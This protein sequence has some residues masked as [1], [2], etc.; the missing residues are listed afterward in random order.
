[1][2]RAA[3]ATTAVVSWQD[4]LAKEAD[5]AAGM[6]AGAGGG[7]WF[8]TRGGIL[9]LGDVAIPDNQIAVVILDSVIENIYYDQDFNPD[10]LTPPRCFALGRDEATLAPHENVVELGQEEHETCTGCPRNEWGSARRGKGKACA[11]RRRLSLL[12]AGDLAGKV[13]EPYEMDHYETSPVALLKLPVTSVKLFANYVKQI[14]A[15]Y[16]RPPFGVF[17]LVRLVPDPKTM[18]RVDISMIDKVPD[19]LLPVIMRR[20]R[21][22]QAMLE[23][24]Q[25]LEYEEPAP[26][27]ARVARGG[28]KVAAKR[29][30]Y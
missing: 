17:S 8:S 13:F 21:E 20:R 29:A 14:S 15:V 24:P 1:M 6:E 30:K 2:A 18:F 4:E 9:S 28:A 22:T 7:G 11:N 19:A 16:R 12:A 26:P 5:I 3:K 10:V 25:V 27:P 23:Q